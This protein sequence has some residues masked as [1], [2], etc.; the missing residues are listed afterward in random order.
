MSDVVWMTVKF[1]ESYTFFT[2]VVVLDD[3]VREWISLDY[4]S[5]VGVQTGCDNMWLMDYYLRLES[6]P[7]TELVLCLEHS[8]PVI[9]VG[10]YG[11]T[12]TLQW[13]ISA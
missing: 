7:C 10:V 2:V 11:A 5:V 6:D 4:V 12:C 13:F 9:C 1:H 8:S 3:N